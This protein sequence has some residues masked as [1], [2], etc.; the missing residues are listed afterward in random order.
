MVNSASYYITVVIDENCDKVIGTA[1]LFTELKLIH[2]A[3][4]VYYFLIRCLCFNF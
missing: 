3:R 2:D 4:K 1:T